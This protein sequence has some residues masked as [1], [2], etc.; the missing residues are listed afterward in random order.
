VLA[1]ST[2]YVRTLRAS[3]TVGGAVTNRDV[4]PI[5]IALAGVVVPANA[6]SIELRPVVTI[7]MWSRIAQMLG[8]LALAAALVAY[9]RS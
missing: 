5:D 1:V 3:A 6:T 2:N 4:F 7:P 8:L 9:R